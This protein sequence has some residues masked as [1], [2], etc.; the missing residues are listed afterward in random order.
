[1]TPQEHSTF[2]GGDELRSIFFGTKKIR[3]ALH[4]TLFKCDD[5]FSYI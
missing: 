3:K 2:Q 1:M 4:S 5:L